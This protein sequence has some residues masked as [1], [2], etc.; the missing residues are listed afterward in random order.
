MGQ[1]AVFKKLGN[2]AGFTINADL[3]REHKL[4]QGMPY[5]LDFL[6]DG[7]IKLTPKAPARRRIDLSKMAIASEKVQFTEAQQREIAEWD[8]MKPVGSEV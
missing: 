5:T 2:S 4:A 3:V 8:A 7:T 1:T 6:D